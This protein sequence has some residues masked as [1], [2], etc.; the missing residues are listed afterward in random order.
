[1][2]I[3]E[4]MNDILASFPGD[5]TIGMEFADIQP[6][7]W[8]LSSIGDDLVVENV[9]GDQR[10]AHHFL[11]YFT[12]SGIND[13]ERLMNSSILTEL[14]IWLTTRTGAEITT[15]DG[16]GEIVS[17]KAGD[18]KLYEIPDESDVRLRYQMSITAEYTVEF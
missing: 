4:A 12:F 1:M 17:I 7:S 15:S 2:N 11:L 9:L 10:R 8:G 3:I 13:Y 14:S 18:G 5:K 6:G 16:T